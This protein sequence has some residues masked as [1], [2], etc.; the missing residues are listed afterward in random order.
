[1]DAANQLPQA[2]DLYGDIERIFR[3]DPMGE[4]NEIWSANK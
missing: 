1:M 3:K 4:Y 2:A